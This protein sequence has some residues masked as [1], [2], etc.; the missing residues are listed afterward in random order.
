MPKKK[1]LSLGEPM[2]VIQVQAKLSADELLQAVEQLSTQELDKFA[3]EV[4]KVQA[5]R[6]APRPSKRESALLLKIKE[7]FPKDKQRRYNKLYSKL[8]EETITEKEYQELLPLVKEQEQL[9]VR[10]LEALIKLA[11]IRQVS[12]DELMDSLGIRPPAY[13]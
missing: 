2:P 13:V 5:R 8:Q 7:A 1:A 11:Q 4:L 3:G 12:V 6:K 10:R 9:N